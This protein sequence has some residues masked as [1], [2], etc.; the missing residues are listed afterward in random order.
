MLEQSWRIG[1]ASGAEVAALEAFRDDPALSVVRAS[2][3][4][5]YGESPPLP[6]GATVYFQDIDDRV[7]PLVK[8]ARL[9][10]Y[11]NT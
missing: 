6:P 11:G 9:E 7:G 1:G 5:I 4:E 8:Y 10:E 2:T 3:T